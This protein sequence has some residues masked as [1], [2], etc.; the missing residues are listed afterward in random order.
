MNLTN[1]HKEVGEIH[2][3]WNI[4]LFLHLPR[5]A[6]LRKT[7]NINEP[8]F[9]FY[10][11]SILT[12][13]RW[14]EKLKGKVHYSGLDMF[15]IYKL[16]GQL[17]WGPGGSHSPGKWLRLR[18]LI[19]KMKA[20]SPAEKEDMYF[21]RIYA[22]EHIPLGNSRS[23]DCRLF[24]YQT[25]KLKSFSQ[26]AHRMA[27]VKQKKKNKEI[28]E[29][30]GRWLMAK[31]NKYHRHSTRWSPMGVK[32]RTVGGGVAKGARPIWA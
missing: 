19:M 13:T 23:V 10:G 2:I 3:L 24:V 17:L 12:D 8:K 4:F 21:A 1:Q 26:K 18:R 14:R 16:R 9:L 11:I 29:N 20:I 30:G 32:W 25:R 5:A 27:W 6:N 31:T 7:K 15:V 28:D 22:H